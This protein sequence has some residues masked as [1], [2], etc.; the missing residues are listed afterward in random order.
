MHN[1]QIDIIWPIGIFFSKEVHDANLA[2]KLN[3]RN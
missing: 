3:T 2:K 1:S